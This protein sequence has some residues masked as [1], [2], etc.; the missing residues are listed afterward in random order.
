MKSLRFLG[1]MALAAAGLHGQTP[2]PTTGA[3]YWSIDPN[4]DCSSQGTNPGY[5]LPIPL[6]SGGT[7]YVCQ[8]AGNFIWLAAGGGYVTSIRV[9]GPASQAGVPASGAVGVDYL[10]YDTNGNN[11]NLD[12][13]S[14]NG[15]ASG[16]DVTFVL[17]ANQPAEVDLLGAPG[18]GPSYTS[19]VTGSVYAV[20]YCA[21]AITCN[22]VLPQL[23]YSA[24]P[25]ISLSVPIAWDRNQWTQW[26]TEGIDDG[27]AH[28]VSLV[29]YNI[30]PPNTQS[31]VATIYTVRVYDSSGAQVGIGTTPAIP[32]YGTYGDLL[33]NI[34]K[35]QLPSGIFKILV[36]GGSN[37]SE[38]VALQAN[39]RAIATLQVGYDSAPATISAAA[40]TTSAL[41]ANVPRG[42]VSSTRPQVFRTL[43]R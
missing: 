34:V 15:A 24:P 2:P 14:P 21:D 12:T 31:T 29:I 8:V 11:L 27:G 26:S 33:S 3:Q 18:G 23:I 10:F 1:L 5:N 6:S 38:V 41:R 42:G 28:R 13:T 39:G 22:A 16:N 36:D 43:P 7:G 40:S 20:L 32:E 37:Y 9:A 30:P 4:L 35:S 19:L 17:S 25:T